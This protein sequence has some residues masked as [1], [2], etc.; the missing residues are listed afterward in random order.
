MNRIRR[1]RPRFEQPELNITAF[2]NLMVILIPFLLI[3]A[4]FSRVTVL[5]LQIPSTQNKPRPEPQSQKK[6]DPFRI[7][8]IVRAS[9][10]DISDG[11]KIINRIP[12]VDG[13]YDY[14]TVSEKLQLIKGKLEEVGKSRSDATILL[15]PQISYDVLVQVM[16]TVRL[17]EKFENG[18][19]VQ[20][21]LFPD[22]SIGEAP[23]S[24]KS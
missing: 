17:I 2:L 7:E 19:I 8:V 10:I 15:E 16:D 1:R 21:E 4:V 5:D 3:T 14:A 24:K 11:T 23:A 20:Y 6:P 9:R 18:R 22:I 13:D 12:M